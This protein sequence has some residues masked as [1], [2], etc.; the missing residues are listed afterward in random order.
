MRL[1]KNTQGHSVPTIR[2]Q[3]LMSNNHLETLKQVQSDK[4][5]IVDYISVGIKFKTF[6]LKGRTDILVCQQQIQHGGIPVL[7]NNGSTALS[8]SRVPALCCLN[9][10]AGFM[11]H[12]CD[13]IAHGAGHP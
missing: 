8:C 6:T 12:G 5:Y 2:D 13:K 10:G 4:L 7:Q 9:C 1:L 11:V 3:N